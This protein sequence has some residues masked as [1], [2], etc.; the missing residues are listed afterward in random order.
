MVKVEIEK[1][2]LGK[3]GILIPD[4]FLKVMILFPFF[5]KINKNYLS[6]IEVRYRIFNFQGF[7]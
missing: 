7:P 6:S 2:K 1:N 3:T 4:S 5:L